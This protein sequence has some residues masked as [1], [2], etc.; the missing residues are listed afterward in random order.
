MMTLVKGKFRKNM[1]LAQRTLAS[2]LDWK[3]TLCIEMNLDIE[4]SMIT[5]QRWLLRYSFVLQQS[6][7]RTWCYHDV[8]TNLNLVAKSSL[9]VIVTSE[10]D[11]NDFEWFE[12]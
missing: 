11:N 8:P 9:K 6:N 10:H 5:G 4:W 2:N 12:F 7:S 3:V 1:S